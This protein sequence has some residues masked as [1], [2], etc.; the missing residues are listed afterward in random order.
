MT[1]LRF[2]GSNIHRHMDKK[3]KKFCA[4]NTLPILGRNFTI[5]APNHKKLEIWTIRQNT[6]PPQIREKYHQQ[7]IGK[8]LSNCKFT[9]VNSIFFQQSI[10]LEWFSMLCFI[11]LNKLH[12]LRSLVF[13]GW[14]GGGGGLE[15][16]WHCLGSKSQLILAKKSRRVLQKL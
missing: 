16:L 6:P 7:K 8:S 1:F 5:P 9:L 12:H 15:H 4:Y 3:K 14:R 11:I 13:P 10:C 2:F